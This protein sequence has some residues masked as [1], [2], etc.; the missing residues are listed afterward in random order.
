MSRRAL[1]VLMA[2]L[3]ALTVLLRAPAH[4]LTGALPAGIECHSPAG[5]LW[6]GSCAR[7]RVPG[8]TLD[9]V[10]WTLHAWP[11]LLGRLDVDLR[12]ADA[13]ASGTARVSL[14]FGGLRSL[15]QLHAT[16]PIDPGRL[17]LFP[18]GWTGRLELAF[19]TIEFDAGR[20]T[21]IE[22][23]ATAHDLAQRNPPLDFGSYELRFEPAAQPRAAADAPIRGALRDLGGPLSVSG[24]LALR[25]GRDY[26]LAGQA[27]ARPGAS[28]DLARLVEYLGASDPQGR[29]AFTLEG[30]F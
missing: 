20:I 26:V 4:W 27:A 2:S 9:G 8:A 15:R 30:S 25:N 29:R 21:R 19:D 5:S 1:L 24:T 28:P 23:V 16:L 7:L 3:F 10:G 17:P 22:G 11:L 12:S 14:G 13:Q 6:H 18:A